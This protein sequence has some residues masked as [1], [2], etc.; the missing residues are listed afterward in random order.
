M[1]GVTS[2]SG[3]TPIYLIE[4]RAPWVTL[5]RGE[6]SVIITW[7]IPITY[8]LYEVSLIKPA[9]LSILACSLGFHGITF[10]RNKIT[11]L[12]IKLM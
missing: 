11:S 1:S 9:L 5:S 4:A 7:V 3:V 12:K 8:L 6:T 10:E 2:V